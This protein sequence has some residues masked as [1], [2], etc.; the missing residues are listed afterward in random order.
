DE[1]S[2]RIRP[3]EHLPCGTVRPAQLVEEYQPKPDL[4]WLVDFE[5]KPPEPLTG[6]DE[7]HEYQ[8]PN[9]SDI[10]VSNRPSKSWGYYLEIVES[11]D[12]PLV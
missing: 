5:A 11:D 10:N 1:T 9:L 6:E 4:S 12:W 8:Q 2:I 3:T 7:D